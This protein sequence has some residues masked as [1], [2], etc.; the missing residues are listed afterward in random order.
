METWLQELRSPSGEGPV[1]GADRQ[2]RA[3]FRLLNRDRTIRALVALGTLALTGL[4]VAFYFLARETGPLD[5]EA[6]RVFRQLLYWAASV[7]VSLLLSLA[8]ACAADA[9]IDGGSDPRLLLEDVRRRLPALLCWWLISIGAWF[10]LG[11]AAGQVMQ[12]LLAL[13]TVAL[14]LGVGTFFVIPAIAIGDGRPLETLGTALRLLRARWGRAL[15]GLVIIGFLYGLAL[16]AAGFVLRAGIDR[17][18]QGRDENLWIVV[19]ALAL[20]YLGYAI[21]TAARES[22]AV[23]LA[24][25]AL[26]D[27]PGEPAPARPRRRRWVLVKQIAAV[28][29]CLVVLLGILGAIFGHHGRSARGSSAAPPAGARFY[30]GFGGPRAQRIE[31]GAPVQLGATRIGTVYDTKLEAAAGR[32]PVM[33]VGFE[34][35]SA[36]V[37]P[38]TR[39]PLTVAEREGFAY[40]QFCKRPQRSR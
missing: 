36:W 39:C 21:A 8:V 24:R 3:G 28:L 22:F 15:A 34:L 38:A 16:T 7:G 23:I 33:Q 14:L 1:R 26:G 13:L 9:R 27:L 19:G 32:P 12:P 18:S 20:G 29:L 11:L 40:L 17:H 35:D 5:R 2:V 10:G 30:T 25:D 37:R 4:W 31:V 6:D